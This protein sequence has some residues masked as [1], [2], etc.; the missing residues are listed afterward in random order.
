M[1]DVGLNLNTSNLTEGKM[2]GAVDQEDGSSP[3][4][5]E[6]SFDWQTRRKTT[7]IIESVKKRVGMRRGPTSAD[8]SSEE[9]T[10]ARSTTQKSRS[11]DE[12]LERWVPEKKALSPEAQKSLSLDRTWHLFKTDLPYGAL[13][14]MF[15]SSMSSKASTKTWVPDVD[16]KTLLESSL[17][18]STLFGKA[19]NT[20]E[21]PVEN[22]QR[23]SPSEE[24]SKRPVYKK[25]NSSP[26]SILN[27][28]HKQESSPPE[29]TAT[30]V[31]EAKRPDSDKPVRHSFKEA[32]QTPSYNTISSWPL[33]PHNL[34]ML[35]LKK[36]DESNRE[37]AEALMSPSFDVPFRKR[38]GALNLTVIDRPRSSSVPASPVFTDVSGKRSSDA[39]SQ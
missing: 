29:A 8:G 32:S 13:E 27:F 37:I 39:H 1:S 4:D 24:R 38:S 23:L 35:D 6:G 14:C 20:L 21:Q 15:A 3:T 7:N 9:V 26:S 18:G 16:T 34:P 28:V 10:T 11:L 25:S 17:A 30:A 2:K 19:S 36:E 31:G 22:S 33:R 12:K 5:S